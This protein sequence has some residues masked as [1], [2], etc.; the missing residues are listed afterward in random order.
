[1]A[2]EWQEIPFA[3]LLAEPVR[4]GIYKKKEFHGRGTKIVNMGELF[5]YPRLRNVPMKRVELSESEKGRFCIQ[6]GDLLFA[7]RSLVAEGAGKC[8]VVLEVLEPTTF[9]SSIIRARPD[10]TKN[11]SL[12]LY[13]YFKSPQ[14]LHALD[15]IRRQVAVAGIT[16]SDLA[17]LNVQM[18]PLS[19]QRAIAK[20]LGALDD[21]IELNRCMNKTLEEMVRAL[22]EDWFVD[23]GPV[24][25][26]AEGRDPG[27][28]RS[29]AALF[30]AGLVHSALGEIPDEWTVRN[31]GDVAEHIRHSVQPH[32]IDPET[33]YIGLE[34][35]PKRCIALSNWTTG[36]VIESNKFEFRRGDLLFGK[37]R[38]YFHKVGVAP[39]DGV[40]STD[41]VVVRPQQQ[42]WFG[43]VLGHVSSV[44]FVHHTDAGST[45][46]RMPRTNWNEMAR[47]R[48]VLPPVSIA[49]SFDTLIRSSV[50]RIISNI[51]ESRTLASQRD[52]LLPKLTSGELPVRGAVKFP[53]RTF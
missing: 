23:F 10:T 29:L 42:A 37:L 39:T 43:F 20:M 24:R 44:E 21:K 22:F 15:S 3:Q 38:P 27:L 7:R 19:H 2:V 35:M 1:M 33:P 11:D 31:L 28:P 8:T 46:T 51:H 47:Y 9:E 45:G 26:K 25:A 48:L 40:C 14:G 30:P 4:N 50:E 13:Y 6:P 36:S 53:G 34:N 5:G 52:A 18:P 17:R 32:Q 49:K 16:G 12:F 41:I